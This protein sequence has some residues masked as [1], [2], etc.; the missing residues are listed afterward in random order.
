MNGLVNMLKGIGDEFELGRILWAVG[1]LAMIIY[2]GVAI[3]LN[4]QAFNAI[5]FGAGFG[6]IL[7]AGG[8]GVAAKDKGVAKAKAETP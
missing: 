7:I 6:S 1:V 5:E 2:Q 8:F 4:K 3:Y